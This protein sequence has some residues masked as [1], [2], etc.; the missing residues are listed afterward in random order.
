MTAL[1]FKAVAVSLPVVLLILD[2]YPLRR[3]WDSTGD[4][5]VRRA[6]SLVGE[7]S[8]YDDEPSLYGPCVRGQDAFTVPI[9]HYDASVGIAQ[10]CY[11]IWF[12]IVKT[13]LPLNLIAFYPLPRE[14]NWLVFPY[15]LSIFATLPISAG[16]F[17]CAG[18]GPDCWRP[19]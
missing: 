14:L 15:D 17:F 12:Y 1:L 6:E 9:E 19:G 4:G 18:A 3:F 10:A 11:A 2:V 13:L 16:L 8:V 7:G 5:S